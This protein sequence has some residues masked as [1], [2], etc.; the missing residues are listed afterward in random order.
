MKTKFLPLV[1]LFLGACAGSNSPSSG[2]QGQVNSPAEITS[3]TWAGTGD[4]TATETDTKRG[5]CVQVQLT[6]NQR[7][8]S[9]HVEGLSFHCDFFWSFYGPYDVEIR[10]GELWNQG[11]RV[12][13]IDSTGM[14]I[15][16]SRLP[17]SL[18][19]FDLRLEA[20]GKARI[21]HHEYDNPGTWKRT[22]D[23]TAELV[24]QPQ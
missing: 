16:V 13:S 19:S 1:F 14:S 20:T 2:A 4:I 12:G 6:L 18:E 22:I 24:F 10:G 21:L 8:D 11:E 9:I 17:A 3:G 23:H 7:A 15:T 5:K